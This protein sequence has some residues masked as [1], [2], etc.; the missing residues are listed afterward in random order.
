MGLDARFSWPTP[1]PA[2][3]GAHLALMVEVS[4]LIGGIP[5]VSPR[6]AGDAR[7]RP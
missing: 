5:L 1:K 2:L 4:A 6:R 3:R 7:A